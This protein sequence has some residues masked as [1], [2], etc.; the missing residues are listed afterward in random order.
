MD[1]VALAIF[2]SRMDLIS[3]EMG[4]VMGRTAQSTI[5]AESHDYSCF[6]A[7]PDGYMVSF[8]DGIPLHT[9]SG[10]FAVRRVLEYWGDDIAP[11]DLFILNDPY[12]SWGNHLPDWTVILPVFIDGI[13]LGFTCTRAHQIDIGGGYFGSY[14]S[15]A[16]EIFE[17]GIRLPPL[18][19]Y[20]R[21]RRRQDVWDLLLLNTRLPETVAGDVSAMIGACRIGERRLQALAL[22]YGTESMR[23]ACAALL[24]YGERVMRHEIAAIPDGAYVG[25][26]V[27]NNDCFSRKEVE[28]RA[29]I[30]IRGSDI[31]VDFAGS[32]PQ[33][34]GFKN[35]PYV[36][37]CAATYLGLRTVIN[38]AAPLN[39]GA[40]RMIEVRAPQG[41]IVNP[42][43]PAPVTFCTTHPAIE[44]VHAC[45][46]ALAAIVPERVSA[47]WG[48]QIFPL[49]SGVNQRGESYAMYHWGGQGAAGA[50]SQ[51]DGMDQIGM[52]NTMGNLRVPSLERYEQLYPVHFLR[53]EFRIDGGGAGKYRGGSGASYV[54]RVDMPGCWSFRCEGL[55]TPS[56]FGVTGGRSG[57]EGELTISDLA[58]GEIIPTPQYGL[59]DLPPVVMELISA[60]GGGWGDPFERDPQAV[61][62]D[63]LNG[64]VSREAARKEYGVVLTGPDLHVDEAETARLRSPSRRLATAV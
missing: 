50:T 60:G 22:E 3:E 18:R 42:R 9:G 5:F 45:W 15:N 48:R 59:R 28:I 57:R 44:I 6:V 39:E 53:H 55:Y 38:P 37:T 26:E 19:L 25:V 24:D 43:P 30:T 1:E 31:T 47:G 23:D 21:G 64:L 41:T 17:E 12:F 58:T 63:V 16:R 34:P 49:T 33:V 13:C 8:A 56:G 32:S 20:E 51:R 52:L 2:Q 36:N 62:A 14:N 27:M 11:G 29:T 40:Y 61:R 35:S 10:G 54:V 7:G 4:I 46:R